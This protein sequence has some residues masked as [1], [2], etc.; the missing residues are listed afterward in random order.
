MNIHSIKIR[1]IALS[2]LCVIAVAGA[3]LGY[4]LYAAS[5]TSHYV[6]ERVRGLLDR[7][8]QE[9]LQRLATVQASAIRAEIDSAFEAAR[10][11]ANALDVIAENEGNGTPRDQRRA[12]L[13]ALLLSVLKD[14]SLFNGTYSAWM[15]DALDGADALFL[16][17]KDLGTDA[18]GRALPYWTRDAAGNIAL[19]PL[20]EYDSRELHPNGVMKGGWFL[21]PQ[22]DGKESIL[23]PLPYIVQGKSVYLA[24]MSV[25]IIVGGKFAGVAGADFDLAFVQ[26]LAEK[27]DTSIYKG[28]GTVSIVTNTGLVVASS[29]DPRAIGGPYSKIE[30]Q[31]EQD[32]ALM[33]K[34]EAVA[35]VDEA[36]DVI[37]VFAPV[38]LGRTGAAWSVIITVPRA[39]V[40]AD[41][42]ALGA[43]LAERSGNDTLWQMV[44]AAVVT[45]LALIAMSLVARGISNP[46]TRLTLAL[47]R[48]AAGEQVAEIAGANRKD[49]IGDISR[50]VDQIRIGVEEEAL[51]KAKE[52]EATRLRAEEERRSTMMNLA[53]GFERAMGQVVESVGVASDQL[54]GAAG[55]MTTA[56][57]KVADSSHTAASASE[58]ASN[59]V[60]TVASAAEELASS[61]VEIKRQVDESARIAADA[62]REAGSTASQVQELSNSAL[63]I[64]KVVDLIRTIAGQTNL[65]ALNATIEA[66]RAGDAGKGFAVV[67]AEVKELA[68]QTSRATA[69]I[70]AQ[71]EEIQGS[72]RASS[73]AIAGITDVIEA[74]NRIAGS[75][76]S[77]VD[78]QGAATREIAH[79]VARASQGTQQVSSN[80]TG[81]NGAAA[82][83]SV[84]ATQVQ[85][86]AATLASQ[87]QTLRR[88]MAEFLG[89]VRA[90]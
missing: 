84:A 16:N 40:M 57:R 85:D 6:T 71:I 81:I 61:I 69:E 2:A 27:V 23:A 75:I 50:A 35:K 19:Q 72:T 41:A 11:M 25:P 18:T 88:V 90:A 9:S 38:P 26:S 52:A 48:L 4:S 60:Q 58:E 43:T 68:E 70:E 89:T 22:A 20:V 67:A 17:R 44:A 42:N 28:E 31:A 30:P 10:N 56:T 21:G 24:T 87:A 80:I 33:R 59:N 55:T 64:G 66:A 37:K 36:K 32:M 15:P 74:I 46:I 12:Q 14:N 7:T 83:S 13:N 54:Q 8:S 62:V 53:D 77:A 82:D 73:Q 5:Q 39:L 86:A 29:A 45:V 76:A 79:N 3:L 47:R 78:Q 65:L 51:R 63:K 49:E 34:G 1:I